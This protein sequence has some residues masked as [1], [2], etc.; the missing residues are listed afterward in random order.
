MLALLEALKMS[1]EDNENHYLEP[2]ESPTISPRSK[3]NA[4][5]SK[6]AKENYRRAVSEYIEPHE[7]EDVY[8]DKRSKSTSPTRTSVSVFLFLRGFLRV[9]RLYRS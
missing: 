2:A 3:K 1:S 5:K 4:G 9:V 8:Q 6:S 7:D